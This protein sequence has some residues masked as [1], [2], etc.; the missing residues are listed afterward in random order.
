MAPKPRKTFDSESFSG[1]FAIIIKSLRD[2]N[3]M[4]VEELAEKSGIP[5]PTIYKWEAADRCP[6]NEQLLDLAK[7]LD[8]DVAELIPRK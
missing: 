4:S 7:A 6:I 5:T 2:K 8:V 1:K 3:K